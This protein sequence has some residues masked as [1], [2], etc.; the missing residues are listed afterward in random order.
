MAMCGHEF[1]SLGKVWPENERPRPWNWHLAEKYE[2]HFDAAI[3]FSDPG[4][5]AIQPLHVPT[6]FATFTDMTRGPVA[7]WVEDA[8]DLLVFTN[9]DTAR[10]C[11]CRDEMKKRVIEFGIREW[12]QKSFH[13]PR[14]DVMTVGNLITIRGDKG[15]D[16]LKAVDAKMDIHTYG[17]GNECL[18]GA[19]GFR[20][21]AEIG[22][23]YPGYKVYFNPG[24][25]ICGSVAE[26]MVAGLP[27]VTMTPQ[28]YTD[29]I[30][31]GV[32]GFIVKTADEAIIVIRKLLENESLREKIAAKGAAVA[33]HRFSIDRHVKD[34]NATLEEVAA[35]R[36]S[37]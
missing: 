27:V 35:V 30:E 33:R 23:I 31:D 37:A 3:A 17:M 15:P 20:S 21:F 2:G 36:A 10:R 12:E 24:P 29:L 7:G 4:L 22:K 8:C 9:W 14:G 1:V 5:R 13:N 34:W 16:V 19:Q 26:A 11:P 18:R 28:T 25:V 32:N 6:I